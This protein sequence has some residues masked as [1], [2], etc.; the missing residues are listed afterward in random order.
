MHMAVDN[1]SHMTSYFNTPVGSMMYGL[2]K[3]ARAVQQYISVLP[4]VLG[5]GPKSNT[6][7]TPRQTV[8]RPYHG[9]DYRNVSTLIDSAVSRPK[10]V[11]VCLN[12]STSLLPAVIRQ[13]LLCCVLQTT[14]CESPLKDCLPH[15]APHWKKD[16]ILTSCIH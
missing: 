11:T 14:T 12:V 10:F 4:L 7:I 5:P 3:P 2:R 13:E 6:K 15:T 16:P 8:C 1:N 9:Q